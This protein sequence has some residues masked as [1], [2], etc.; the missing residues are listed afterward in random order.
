MLYVFPHIP[1]LTHLDLSHTPYKLEHT[2][3]DQ[4][5][6]HTPC[7]KVL[8]LSHCQYNARDLVVSLIEHCGHME[9]IY[10][11]HNA[12]QLKDSHLVALAQSYNAQLRALGL[13]NSV[14]LTD[15]GVC[16]IGRHCPSLTYLNLH[17]LHHL[18][19][20]AFES[21]QNTS[22]QTLDLSNT[23]VSETAL[24]KLIKNAENLIFLNLTECP[25]VVDFSLI[26]IAESCG[27][28]VYLNLTYCF[29]VSDIGILA[30]A[31][32]CLGLQTLILDYCQFISDSA[33]QLLAE[34]KATSP[35][36]LQRLSLL[37]LVCVPSL[38]DM[39]IL[40]STGLL[41]DLVELNL[42]GNPS[43]TDMSVLHIF[44]VACRLQT[45]K[46]ADC[47]RITN[48]CVDKLIYTPVGSLKYLDVSY[49]HVTA[50]RV[51]RVRG[52]KVRA[53]HCG[54]G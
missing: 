54:L 50:E 37:S 6:R 27:N 48:L 1:H 36:S 10:F 42:S 8:N 34:H 12:G 23:S 35:I 45:F 18:S 19:S 30:I 41:E 47:F 5:F 38:S 24:T 16:A 39:S 14:M 9:E 33:L 3:F 52:V 28:L 17:D 40:M 20:D 25:L 11:D 7:L 53:V 44:C 46:I 29:K 2:L 21:I 43:L 13:A 15:I 32:S 4:V 51:G 22:L 49:T 31:T 26:Q